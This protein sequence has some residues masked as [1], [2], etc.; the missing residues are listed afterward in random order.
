M[1]WYENWYFLCFEGN[2]D[3][4]KWNEYGMCLAAPSCECT[5]NCFSFTEFHWESVGALNNKLRLLKTKEFLL[6]DLF[7]SF[8]S[9]PCL[10]YDY[11]INYAYFAKCYLEGFASI[12]DPEK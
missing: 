5:I 11:L 6:K 8:L 12:S 2:V 7:F 9:S 4:N 10:S 1:K 3:A